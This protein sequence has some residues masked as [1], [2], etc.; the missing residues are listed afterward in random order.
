M[1]MRTDRFAQ[2]VAFPEEFREGARNAVVTC[3]RI[4]RDEKVT[5]ITDESCLVIAASLAKELDALGCAWNAFVLELATR[6]L[7]NGMPREVLDDMETSQV[8]IF[9]VQV[10]PNEL[11]SRMDMT[12]VVNRRQDAPCAYGEHY[13]GRDGAGHARGL[14]MRWTG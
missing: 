12:D 1:L 4:Q 9:A 7:R 3:L 5:L 8:S 14:S 2:T 11:R 10:Q 13:A 6:P